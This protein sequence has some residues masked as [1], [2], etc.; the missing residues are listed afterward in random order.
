MLY[1][2]FSSRS[3]LSSSSSV[4]ESPLLKLPVEIRLEILKYALSSTGELPNTKDHLGPCSTNPDPKSC[5][6]LRQIQSLPN[7][8]EVSH[9]RCS[10]LRVNK[11][12]YEEG[13]EVLCTGETKFQLPVRFSEDTGSRPL[14]RN[15]S[16]RQRSLMRNIKVIVH[17]DS[18]Y[19][20]DLA[21]LEDTKDEWK[22]WRAGFTGLRH[23]EVVF[24]LDR[25]MCFEY[26]IADNTDLLLWLMSAWS[27]VKNVAMSLADQPSFD[28][29]VDRLRN[30]IIK[31]ARDRISHESWVHTDL[32]R[33]ELQTIWQE[34][35]P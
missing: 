13:T 19:F 11:Q 7:L 5:P 24:K 33:A 10:I 4:T 35:K 6:S 20:F 28:P 2:S 32:T 8:R 31:R 29:R 12:I 3:S 17:L 9:P 25:G 34:W 26:S 23:V 16:E 21:K 14:S 22:E 1:F 15:I 30:V 27:G 18:R